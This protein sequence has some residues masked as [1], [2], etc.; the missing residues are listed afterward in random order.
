MTNPKSA[1]SVRQEE[2]VLPPRLLVYVIMGLIVFTLVLVA[3]AFGILRSCE[4]SLRPDGIFSEM[5]LG[6]IV[7]RSNV[8]EDLFGQV[9]NGQVLIRAQRRALTHYGWLDQEKRF[10]Q[11]PIDV[12]IDLYIKSEVP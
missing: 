3:I 8:Y 6:P 4:K 11:V 2:D 1:S 5:S 7:E 10:V 9:G 12:A